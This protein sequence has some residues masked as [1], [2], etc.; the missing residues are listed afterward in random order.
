M[1]TLNSLIP[2]ARFVPPSELLSRWAWVDLGHDAFALY[3]LRQQLIQALIGSTHDPSTSFQDNPPKHTW[4]TAALHA[5]FDTNARI[6]NDTVQV[7]L[8]VF[9]AL[10]KHFRK[11]DLAQDHPGY[12]LF[13]GWIHHPSVSTWI[14]MYFDE[15]QNNNLALVPLLV[16]LNDI[17]KITK[18]CHTGELY[19]NETRTALGLLDDHIQKIC[20]LWQHTSISVVRRSLE[21]IS[22]SLRCPMSVGK[23]QIILDQLLAWKEQLQEHLTT[24]DFWTLLSPER[25][26]FFYERIGNGKMAVD[27]E[28]VKLVVRQDMSDLQLLEVILEIYGSNDEDA[29]NL[30]LDVL[31]MLKNLDDRNEVD[32]FKQSFKDILEA[33]SPNRL[34]LCFCQRT[35]MDH[36]LLVDLLLSNETDFLIFFVNY[37]KHLEHNAEDFVNIC[38]DILEQDIREAVGM[39]H[40]LIHVLQAGGFP[41]NPSYLIHRVKLVLKLIQDAAVRQGRL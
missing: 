20:S 21:I 11:C 39:L 25:T 4:V 3:A 30:Q 40:C 8:E 18:L 22:R 36:E 13:T 17:T 7:Y 12:T 14:S 28:C 23:V 1:S 9:H 24:D 29:V 2:V 15:C 38:C 37:L 19:P 10:F 31:Q 34:F 35:G 16:C 32:S 5:L 26:E 27:R 6:V 41:Y 33:T